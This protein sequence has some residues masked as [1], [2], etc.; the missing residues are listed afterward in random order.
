V[1]TLPALQPL[2]RNQRCRFKGRRGSIEEIMEPSRIR[3]DEAI[4]QIA[5]GNE[6]VFIDTRNEIAWAASDQKLPGAKGIPA[7]ESNCIATC[8]RE[9]NAL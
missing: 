5:R 2:F 7:D 8:C 1:A 4:H 3:A 9:I 6:I